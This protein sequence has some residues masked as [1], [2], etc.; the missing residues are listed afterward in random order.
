MTDDDDRLTVGL[1]CH[2]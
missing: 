2:I 1:I